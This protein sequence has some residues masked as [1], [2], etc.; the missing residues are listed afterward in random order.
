MPGSNGLWTVGQAA[1][2]AKTAATTLR[3]YE[4]E[5][6]LVPTTKNRAGYR[7]YDREAVERLR[8]IR[9]AQAVGFSLDDIRSLLQLD[10][11][12]GKA[13]RSTVQTL[14]ERRMAEM[15]EKMKELNRVRDALGRALDRCRHSSGE[16]AVLNDLRP[17]RK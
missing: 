16:C 17:K 14:L 3:F 8:F 13:C 5:G 9:S 1:A 15:D 7:L 4:R 12:D 10:A 2:A 11:E 6:I